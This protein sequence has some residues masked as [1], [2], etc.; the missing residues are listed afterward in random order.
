MKTI[1][2]NGEKTNNEK[3]KS[4]YDIHGAWGIEE[5][6]RKKLNRG[7]FVEKNGGLFVFS[8]LERIFNLL[9]FVFF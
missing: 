7:R 2:K 5:L 9:I 3:E 4:F 1:W 6:S 8:C